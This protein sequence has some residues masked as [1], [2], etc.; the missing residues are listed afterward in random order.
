MKYTELAVAVKLTRILNV[1]C[2]RRAHNVVYPVNTACGRLE[3]LP[4]ESVSP[5]QLFIRSDPLPN[6][7]TLRRPH[8]H[9]REIPTTHPPPNSG[10]RLLR[11][12]SIFCFMHRLG[13]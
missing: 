4:A 10:N 9:F 5:K 3:L 6:V 11:A 12:L 1:A 13:G 7:V 8:Q 2:S